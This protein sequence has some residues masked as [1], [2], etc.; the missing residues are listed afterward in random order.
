[1]KNYTLVLK[2]QIY[3]EDKPPVPWWM[4]GVSEVPEQTYQ[5]RKQGCGTPDAHL[6][7]SEEKQLWIGCL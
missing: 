1:M 7:Q 6:A 2:I 5:Y 4:Q 3:E